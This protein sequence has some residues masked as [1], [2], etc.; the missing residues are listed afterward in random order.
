MACYALSMGIKEDAAIAA[1]LLHN[2]IEDCNKIESELPVSDEA[3]R[4]VVLLTHE[5]IIDSDREAVMDSF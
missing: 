3:K 4:I 5:K 1:L 2:V